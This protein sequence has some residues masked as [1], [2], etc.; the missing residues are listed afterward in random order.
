MSK[1]PAL[2]GKDLI[3]ILKKLGFKT[4]RTKGSHNFLRHPDGRSTTVPVHSNETL[5][6]GILSKILRDCEINKDDII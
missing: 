6:S 5:G 2:S 3:K 4:V 1:Y